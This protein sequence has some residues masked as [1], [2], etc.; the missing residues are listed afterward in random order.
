MVNMAFSRGIC[1]ILFFAILAI[2]Q[3]AVVEAGHKGNKKGQDNYDLMVT[4]LIAKMLQQSGGGGGGGG[5]GGFYPIYIPVPMH[6]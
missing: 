3:I 1:L 2:Y 5:H 4:G 6:G